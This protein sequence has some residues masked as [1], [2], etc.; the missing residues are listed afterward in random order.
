M[1]TAYHIWIIAVICSVIDVVWTVAKACLV[2]PPQIPYN[3]QRIQLESFYNQRETK[4]K[5]LVSVLNI[6]AKLPNKVLAIC[7]YLIF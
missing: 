5:F 3:A 7:M 6:N 2:K 1:E 4:G